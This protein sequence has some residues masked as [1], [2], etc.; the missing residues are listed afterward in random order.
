MKWKLDNVVERHR[1]SPYTFYL[2][3]QHVLSQLKV[4]DLVKLI[5][6]AEETLENGCEAER[7]WVEIIE[8]KDSEFRGKLDNKP[9]YLD[10]PQYGD[11]IDF[12]LIHICDTQ[13]DDPHSNDM[14][15][16]FDKRVTVSNDVLSRNEFNFLLRFE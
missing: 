16:F 5:F 13:L 10:S 7:M 8:R 6:M 11:L 1:E 14:D 12:N 2:P 4:G 3:S 15:F 9:Y